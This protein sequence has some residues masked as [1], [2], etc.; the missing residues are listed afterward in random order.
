MRIHF[1]I[2]FANQSVNFQKSFNWILSAILSSHGQLFWIDLYKRRNCACEIKVPQSITQKLQSAKATNFGEHFTVA[3]EDGRRHEQVA[4]DLSL[5]TQ[6][7]HAVGRLQQKTKLHQSFLLKI[8]GM[9]WYL[10]PLM[11]ARNLALL[12]ILVFSILSWEE[13]SIKVM[14]SPTAPS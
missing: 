6:S 10:Q 14:S 9:C 11:M 12:G 7:L 2:F 13:M 8:V 5:S 3:K 1:N 4:H